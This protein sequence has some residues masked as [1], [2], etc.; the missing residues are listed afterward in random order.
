MT[1]H[2]VISPSENMHAVYSEETLSLRISMGWVEIS[3]AE[4]MT[5]VKERNARRPMDWN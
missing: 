3:E 5:R 4:Y 1:R 2:Y